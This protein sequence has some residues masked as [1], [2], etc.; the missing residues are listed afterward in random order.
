MNTS[1]IKLPGKEKRKPRGS[2]V[3]RVLG[4]L[5][6]LSI[7]SAIVVGGLGAWLYARYTAPGPLQQ[8]TIVDIPRNMDRIQVANL[9]HD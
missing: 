8:A 7:I 3:G 4:W 5:F 2:A 9:L 6:A 1:P